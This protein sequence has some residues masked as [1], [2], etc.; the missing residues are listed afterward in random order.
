MRPV[1]QARL[2]F[3]AD[4]LMALPL[5][6][7]LTMPAVAQA[8]LELDKSNGPTIEEIVA[9]RED[10]SR[11]VGGIDASP[12]KWPSMAAIYMRQGDDQPFNFC[13]GTIIGR[14]WVL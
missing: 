5:L 14:Q 13:G 12:G 6:L 1:D 11:I 3:S 7:L 8:R 10:N 2:L 4:K 9:A